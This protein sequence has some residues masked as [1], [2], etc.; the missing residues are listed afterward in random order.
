M[1]KAKEPYSPIG[2]RVAK[3]LRRVRAE[4]GLTQAMLSEISGVGMANVSRI[5]RGANPTIG[6]LESLSQA[7]CCDITELVKKV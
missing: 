3:N 7:L 5:E 4:Q 6:V 2:E 1:T